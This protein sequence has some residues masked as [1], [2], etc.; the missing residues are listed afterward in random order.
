MLETKQIRVFSRET[1][2]DNANILHIERLQHPVLAMNNT[3][4][5]LLVYC[6]DHIVRYFSVHISPSG[7]KVKLQSQQAFSV[8]DIVGGLN[9]CLQ[10]IVRFPPHGEVSID[11]MK[12]TPFVI[13][14]N[15]SLYIISKKGGSWEALRIAHHTE[16]YW[17]SAQDD[18]VDEFSNNL[19]AFSGATVNILTN[20]VFDAVNGIDSKFLDRPL[21]ISV[22]FY[23][24]TVLIQK[25]IFVGIEKRL[26]LNASLDICQ[27]S[28]ETK[29]QLFLHLIIRHLLILG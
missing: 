14:G 21:T 20:I 7:Q 2:L 8:K 29:S 16:H 15:G 3:S 25:G 19:W 11:V 12:E 22:D 4:S 1:K 6:S 24:L 13:L 17:M 10:S 5:H 26:S 9:D 27:F 28:P 18:E 23:P